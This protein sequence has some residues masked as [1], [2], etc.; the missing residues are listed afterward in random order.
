MNVPGYGILSIHVCVACSRGGERRLVSDH[1]NAH[2]MTFMVMLQV[3]GAVKSLLTV[4]LTV[5]LAGRRTRLSTRSN[6]EVSLP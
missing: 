5:V 3:V 6:L 2:E 1:G 4:M